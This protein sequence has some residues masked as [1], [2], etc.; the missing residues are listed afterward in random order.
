MRASGLFCLIAGILA[1]GLAQDASAEEDAFLA[2]PSNAAGAFNYARVSDIQV[3]MDAGPSR[4]SVLLTD[5]E[6]IKAFQKCSVI[7]QRLEQ[8]GLISLPN[9]FGTVLLASSFVASL[10]STNNGGCRLN[11]RNGRWV[12]VNQPCGAVHKALAAE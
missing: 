10:I 1:G 12:P 8:N 9:S 5:G 11:L 4:C 6:E 7:T 3:F 2:L